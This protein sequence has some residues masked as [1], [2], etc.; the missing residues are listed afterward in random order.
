MESI[1]KLFSVVCGVLF[2]CGSV[3]ILFSGS[4]LKSQAL[5]TNEDSHASTTKLF[6]E[7]QL[8]ASLSGDFGDEERLVQTDDKHC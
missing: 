3:F 5:D 1:P 8:Q 2:L 6:K 4:S 7:Q